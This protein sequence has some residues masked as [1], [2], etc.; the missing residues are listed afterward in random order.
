MT[1]THGQKHDA[2]SAGV[3]A[4]T[5]R[6]RLPRGAPILAAV[7]VVAEEEVVRVRG[8][9]AKL[10][11]A[12]NGSTGGLTSLSNCFLRR[13]TRVRPRP[14]RERERQRADAPN[15]RSRSMNCPCTSPTTRIGALSSSIAGCSSR[16]SLHSAVIARTSSS[17]MIG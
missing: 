17:A 14:E 3:A 12:P 6:G 7:D 10:C 16:I 8:Q 4:D 5:R 1:D 13:S 2:H 9:A 11:D 15:N